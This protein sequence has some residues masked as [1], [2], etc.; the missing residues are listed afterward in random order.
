MLATSEKSF[1]ITGTFVTPLKQTGEVV[2]FTGTVFAKNGVITD[3][4]RHD[5]DQIP[6]EVKQTDWHIN[7]APPSVIY[8]GLADLHT[9]YDYN[10]LPIWE[11]PEKAECG[12]DNRFEWRGCPEYAD[13]LKKEF[14]ILKNNWNTQISSKNT[15][16]DLF[17][18]LSE[19]QAIAGGSTVLQEP[20]VIDKPEKSNDENV[21][22]CGCD[23]EDLCGYTYSFMA[24]ANDS[25][26]RKHL[27]LRSTGC[28]DDLGVSAP[29]GSKINS[30]IQFF[31]PS[32]PTVNNQYNSLTN[33]YPPQDTS[34]W[35][36]NENS[37]YKAFLAYLKGKPNDDSKTTPP[38]SYLVH[39]AEGRSG[40]L[41]QGVDGYSR[42]EF[43]KLKEDVNK[44]YKEGH[45]DALKNRRLGIIHGCGINLAADDDFGFV[46]NNGISIIWSPVSNLLLYD[47]TPSF[48]R[49]LR[50]RKA[51]NEVNLCL[52]SDWSPSGS[53]HVFDESRFAADFLESKKA[54]PVDEIRKD[55]FKMVTLN[56]AKL[57]GSK[58]GTIET[59]MFADF[60]VLGEPNLYSY[61]NDDIL[62]QFFGSSDK[63]TKL[64]IIGGNVIFGE[65][66]YFKASGTEDC[67]SMQAAEGCRYD[68]WVYV[69]KELNIN[70]ADAIKGA[71]NALAG[72]GIKVSRFMACDDEEYTNRIEILRDKFIKS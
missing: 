66:E 20:D 13:Q 8:P 50:N 33:V 1:S 55:V 23:D 56:P 31:T 45:K 42:H 65:K 25:M 60:F 70:L 35:Q 37:A 58:T 6:E 46:K 29:A 40:Y 34:N 57:L 44:I 41:K 39:I 19:I 24:G 64:V 49:D 38:Y 5:L 16:G 68:K 59:G 54:A 15:V 11:R 52:G 2:S 61:A 28:I 47:D 53:K 67:Q 3:I 26:Q 9:H 72:T 21:C 32:E 69:P 48:Y 51:L 17:L 7:I 14:F 10:L 43:E 36:V 4:K 63:D 30:E 12:W 62:S 27:L 71:Q 22:M 18:F